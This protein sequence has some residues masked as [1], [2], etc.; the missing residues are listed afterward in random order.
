MRA[1]ACMRAV[2]AWQRHEEAAARGGC[3]RAES[4]GQPRTEGAGADA[5]QT[6]ARRIRRLMYEPARL[7][8]L[9]EL[10]ECSSPASLLWGELFR[11]EL[12]PLAPGRQRDL[13]VYLLL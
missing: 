1:R 13:R 4:S 11:R 9:A 6:L 3:G 10:D 5:P 7:Q 2:R 12:F 8:A